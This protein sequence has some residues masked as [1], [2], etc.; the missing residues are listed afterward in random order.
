M[1]LIAPTHTVEVP[2]WVTYPEEDW[3][4][5]TPEQ[6]G[7]D[8]E[9]FGRWL[10]GL[11]VR[12]ARFGGEDHGGDRYGAVLTRGGCLVH[13]WGTATTGTRPPPWA[14]PSPGWSWARRRPTG[15]STRTSRSTALGPARASSPIR[16]S[17]SPPATTSG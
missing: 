15:S 11:E 1:D 5:V 16:T 2:G 6:A 8:P 9:G 14:R 13:A 17:T 12:G 4:T 10:A 7:L 3:Q